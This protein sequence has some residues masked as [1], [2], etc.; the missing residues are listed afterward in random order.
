L[1]KGA[2][3]P[4]AA[5]I[6]ALAGQPA[7]TEL[8]ALAGER[9]DL[10]LV[11]GAVRD[12]L[13]GRRPRELDVTVEDGAADL[14]ALL[15]ARLPDGRETVHSRF[16]TAAVSSAAGAIDI[17]QRRAESYPHPGALPEVRPG[18]VAEDLERRDFTVNAM[19]VPLGGPRRGQ[20]DAVE[21]ALDDLRARRLRVMHERSFLDDP[22]R[23]L[24]LARYAARLGYS[25]E[26][27]TAALARAALRAGALDTVSG[28]RVGAEI[29][30]AAAEDDPLAA[31]AALA[32]LGVLGALGL[33]P[34]YDR[35]LAARALELLPLEG[36]RLIPLAV[37]FRTP[38]E[39]ARAT[40][41]RRLDDFGF[42]A[43]TRER[44]LSAAF[45]ADELAAALP[46][47]ARPSQLYGLLAAVPVETVAVA[48]AIT[49]AARENARRWI[50][51]LRGVRLEID[52]ADLLRAGVPQGPE[53]GARLRRA[54]DAKLDG[55]LD[56]RGA[57]AELRVAL[58]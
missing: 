27:R 10:A 41:A 19:A 7:G 56:G 40:T 57:E 37:A 52:G 44:L 12:L 4:G 55:E 38:A 48:G 34:R 58:A 3:A 24:R 21:H 18:S 47:A 33:P 25:V 6:E 23:L 50:E 49:R 46:R 9:D 31:F 13:S 43:D 11:G 20:L 42:H 28:A 2:D 54:L 30:L 22:T 29:Q 26:D 1:R 14:A 8:L 53:I 45:D 32:E 35:R 15:A 16:G 39:G 36:L 51:Q 5:V 17:A